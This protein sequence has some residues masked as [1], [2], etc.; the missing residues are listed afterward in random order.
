MPIFHIDLSTPVSRDIGVEIAKPACYCDSTATGCNYETDSNRLRLDY[1]AD[2]NRKWLEQL[3]F[4]G[5]LTGPHPGDSGRVH[6]DG[7]SRAGVT[8]CDQDRT[9]RQGVE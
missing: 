4:G 5:H 9:D 3:T 2:G 8:L 7:Q 6:G 1:T